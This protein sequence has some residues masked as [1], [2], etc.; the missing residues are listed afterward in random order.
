MARAEG[1]RRA[2]ARRAR[3]TASVGEAGG[4]ARLAL[5]STFAAALCAAATSFAGVAAG[6][7]AEAPDAP[8]RT[9]PPDT[10]ALAAA[11]GGALL[12]TIQVTAT[13]REAA[14]YEVPAPVL[15]VSAADL[16]RHSPLTAVDHL[17]GEP[18]L[19]V[20]QTTPGQGVVIVRGLK[21]SEIL[22][23]VDGFRLNNAIFRNAPN[24]YV[25]LVNAWNLERVEAVRGP[26]GALYGGDAMGGVVQFV[27]TRPRFEGEALRARGRVRA[28]AGSAD[29]SG[30]IAVEG[31]VGRESAVLHAGFSH[32][33]VGRLRVG[34]GARLPYTDFTSTAAF[35]SAFLQ[36]AP[37]HELDV[38]VQWL[39]QPR[40]A[41]YDGLVA[42]FGQTRPDSSELWFQPQERRFGQVRWRTTNSTFAFDDAELQAGVQR[43]VDDRITRDFEGPTRDYEENASVLAGVSGQFG[44]RLPRDHVLTYGFEAYRDRVTATRRRETLASGAI[45]DVAARFPDGS[46]M[47]W[48]A[49]YVADEWRATDRLALT[50]GARWSKYRIEVPS[51]F[52]APGTKLSPDDLSGNAGVSY[53]IVR[54]TRL[55]ANVGRGFR[56]PNVF[57]LGNFGVRQGRFGIPNPDL[58]PESVLTYDVGVKHEGDALRFEAFAFESK[59]RDKITQVLTGEFDARGRPIVQSRNA[60]ALTLRGLEGATEWRFADTMTLLASATW[61]RG[62]ERLA[63][64]E[65]PADRIPPLFGRV[66]LRHE[67]GPWEAETWVDWADAQRRLSPRDRVDARIDPEGTGGWATANARVRWRASETLKLGL[68][69]QNAFDRRYRE[70]GSGFDAPG[71]GVVATVEWGR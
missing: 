43:V 15:V 14:T 70:H 40:T 4:T 16:E 23:L 55:V 28:Q 71:R 26:L 30:T 54:G 34:G 50:A 69:V 18:G 67:H 20:Q 9:P 45:A 27:S 63:G 33:H 56:P 29:E 57:D 52:G 5:R 39:R 46:T 68:A 12:E 60:T 61:T 44:K 48:A 21:G 41:R 59:Y 38:R 22:H 36:P 25:A 58:E 32:Q 7:P 13:R 47:A 49:A 24:Q 42:G 62:E 53:E 64:D 6:A 31:E 8:V 19:Y 65:Y 1:V 66:A 51:V 35:A 17:R 10:R 37:G 2:G 3:L 11:T